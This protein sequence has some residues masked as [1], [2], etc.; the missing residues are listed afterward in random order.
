MVTGFL[1]QAIE[2]GADVWDYRLHSLTAVV[3]LV[4]TGAKAA[5][6]LRVNGWKGTTDN[7]CSPALDG[8]TKPEDRLLWEHIKIYEDR[9]TGFLRADI[10]FEFCQ[11]F[12]QRPSV[13]CT[14][15][16][17][18]LR[19]PSYHHV[20]PIKLLL[21]WA[22]R[23]GA[24]HERSWEDLKVAINNHPDKTVVWTRPGMPVFLSSASVKIGDFRNEVSADRSSMFTWLSQVTQ[25]CNDE[26]I[27]PRAPKRTRTSR[28]DVTELCKKLKLDPD[29]KKDRNKASQELRKRKKSETKQTTEQLQF[30]EFRDS[31]RLKV[32][33]FDRVPMNLTMLVKPFIKHNLKSVAPLG[34]INT[35][36]ADIWSLPE[37][38]LNPGFEPRPTSGK[39]PATTVRIR[40][41]TAVTEC[42]AIT[43]L[44]AG[45]DSPSKSYDRG[46]MSVG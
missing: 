39:L 26:A 40:E 9:T 38:N 14:S 6:M 20:C 36:L 32:S 34:S 25:S 44:N 4:T 41:K 33:G 7:S 1:Q 16:P 21:V 35:F 11:S 24:V 17:Y 45:A 43:A 10:Q 18:E 8:L 23:T 19:D 42:D 3:L 29:D 5:N 37:E 27:G 28:E 12:S 30:F 15:H 22:L 13:R 31:R 46:P 2:Y